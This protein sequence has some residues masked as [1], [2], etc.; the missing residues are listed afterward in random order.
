MAGSFCGH[1][2]PPLSAQGRTRLPALLSKLENWRCTQLY[3]SDLLRA[4]ETAEFIPWERSV[5]LQ[6]RAGLREIYFGAWEGLTWDEIEARDK[7]KATQWL[8]EY[9]RGPIPG[10]EDYWSFAER[11]QGEADFLFQRTTN[12]RVGA[13]TH[14]G[15]IQTILN[16]RCNISQQQAW[17]WTKGYGAIVVI[18]QQGG[19]AYASAEASHG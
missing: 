3:S 4:K 19:I 17:Q 9:P 15:V 12:G 16:L 1:S 13:V 11:V 5:P 6:L 7:D 2:D 10:G 8:E 18:T 14:A